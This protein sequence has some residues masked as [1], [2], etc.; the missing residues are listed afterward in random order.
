M[1]DIMLHGQIIYVD[2]IAKLGTDNAEDAM[3]FVADVN[4]YIASLEKRLQELESKN[5]WLEAHNKHL[6]SELDRAYVTRR[7]Y[8]FHDFMVCPHC[9]GDGFTEALDYY[10]GYRQ[11]DC[12]RC[13]TIGIVKRRQEQANE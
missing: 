8:D 5:A 6:M 2:G 9:R 12:E 11:S 3:G 4:R 10:T 13:D 1:R 7:G